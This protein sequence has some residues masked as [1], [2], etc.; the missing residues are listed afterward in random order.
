MTIS[1]LDSSFRSCGRI[2][3]RVVVG[4]LASCGGLQR[5]HAYQVVGR[6]GE[7][8]LPVHAGPA[9]MVEFAETA[10]G[11]HPAEDFF[12]AFA[13]ALTDVVAGVPCRPL[14]QSATV[15]FARD[16]RGGLQVP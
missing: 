6:R 14:V 7:E 12:D 13:H 5:A 2:D 8:K 3:R 15:L 4:A 1:D 10:D 9:T 16:V 11:L